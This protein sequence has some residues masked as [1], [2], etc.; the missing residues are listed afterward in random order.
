LKILNVAQIRAADAYT[1]EHEPIS[2]PDLMERAA[3]ALTNRFTGK[4][5]APC[6]VVVYCGW[7]NNGGDGLCLARLLYLRGY[8]VQVIALLPDGIT[9]SPDFL[10]N[11]NR[12][13]QLPVP[14]AEITN[15]RQ[16]LPTLPHTAIVV[17]ALFG[18]GLNRPVEGMAAQMIEH[19][20]RHTGAV[21]AID[22]PS[23]LF[24]DAPVL[25]HTAIVKAKHTISFEAP[26]LAFLFAENYPYVG[27]WEVVSIGLHPHFLQTTATPYHYLTAN[28]IQP[29]L[30][31]LPKF[32]HKGTKGHVLF[33]GGS[34]GKMGAAILSAKAALKIGAG[35]VSV[36]VPKVGYAIMQTAL[37]E[38]MVLPIPDENAEALQV[39]PPAIT[40]AANG[41]GLYQSIAI[42]PGMGS[43]PQGA[44]T[45]QHFLENVRQPMV[46]D[47]DALNRIALAGLLDLVPANS[48]LT[49]HPKEFERLA[50]KTG[51]AF[52][53]LEKQRQLA[54]Q[55]QIY[56]LLKGAHTAIAC[57]NA[58]VFFNSTGTP[59][60]GTAGSGDVLTGIIAGLLAQGYSS[61]HSALI[62]VYL[63]GTSGSKAA[64][65][66]H[67][68]ITASDL[69]GFLGLQIG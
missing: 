59:A 38:V 67:G 29:I 51:N 54:Q 8:A 40:L 1:I 58:D 7:G 36:F 34:I 65:A 45:L 42:G 64:A 31:T 32:A 69:I 13:K 6:E 49:P 22:M 10:L 63:H 26:K 52:N 48:I 15:E 30:Q 39:L 19:I 60:M 41:T 2:S 5:K 37:P 16:T 61:L 17:D 11:Y 3:A 56:L 44:K 55:Y 24:A 14:V 57:P 53:R 20:N 66:L 9:P 12:L 21:V 50:G 35:L 47:A 18:S 25:P 23:G 62:G 68:C 46:I 28:Q 33:I 4:F 43:T 27:E